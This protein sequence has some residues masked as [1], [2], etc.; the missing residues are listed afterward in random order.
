MHDMRIGVTANATACLAGCIYALT[1]AVTAIAAEPYPA[2]PVRVVAP[3]AP[4]GGTD[5]VARVVAQQFAEQLGKSFIVD[6]RTGASGMIAM[7][8]SPRPRPTG[9]RCCSP[10][11]LSPVCR[12]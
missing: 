2:K 10:T 9:T 8:S 3:F 12:D 11:R 6:N 4:G 1:S 7:K 5:T